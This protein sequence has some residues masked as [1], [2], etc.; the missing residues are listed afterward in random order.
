MKTYC[1]ETQYFTNWFHS[2]LEFAEDGITD[3]MTQYSALLLFVYFQQ[4]FNELLPTVGEFM[5]VL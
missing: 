1:S 2:I 4:I 3:M 5:F